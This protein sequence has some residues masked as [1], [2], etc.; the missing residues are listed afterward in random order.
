[1]IAETWPSGGNESQS[2]TEAAADQPDPAVR[3]ELRLRG[4]PRRRLF[5][6]VGDRGTDRELSEL[7]N[8]CGH[9]GDAAGGDLA[10]E[11]NESGFLDA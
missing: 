1:M 11:F 10:G 2:A 5:D 6:A 9:D 7:G 3:R 4:E 8:V